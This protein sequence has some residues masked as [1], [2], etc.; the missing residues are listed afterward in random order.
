MFV[1]FVAVWVSFHDKPPNA[2]INSN[3]FSGCKTKK[4]D[5]NQPFLLSSYLTLYNRVTLSAIIILSMTM[6]TAKH[7]IQ[8][9]SRD[10]HVMNHGFSVT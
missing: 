8:R 1:H 2:D 10:V 9:A 4:V 6:P 7:I 3:S 5:V